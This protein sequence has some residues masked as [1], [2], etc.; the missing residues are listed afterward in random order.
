MSLNRR[1]LLTRS[2]GAAALAT[3]GTGAAAAVPAAT[4][5]APPPLA[6]REGLGALVID[7]EMVI[8]DAADFRMEPGDEAVVIAP[9]M[10]KGRN[11]PMVRVIDGPTVQPCFWDRSAALA[12]LR[13]PEGRPTHYP[14]VYVLGRVVERRPLGAAA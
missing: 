7:G 14:I 13:D 4:P 2:V 11:A 12:P 3:V 10:N 5:E 6:A 1:E 9:T 8:F